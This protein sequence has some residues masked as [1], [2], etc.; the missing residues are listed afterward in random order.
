M[1]FE[2]P[3]L[4]LS[5]LRMNP[6]SLKYSL[7][8]LDHLSLRIHFPKILYFSTPKDDPDETIRVF[9]DGLAKTLE[10]L[11]IYAGSLSLDEN[12]DKPGSLAVQ[13]PYLTA[14]QILRIA[15][16][17]EKYDFAALESKE[18][19]PDG[20]DLGLVW[21]QAPDSPMPVLMAQLSLIRGGVL[22]YLGIHHC[23][24]GMSWKEYLNL[25]KPHHVWLS[26]HQI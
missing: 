9:L 2:E 12:A 13:A 1:V 26:K 18:F 6:N 24:M 7:S 11:P 21:P 20:I 19:P 25:S 5:E 15:D 4:K 16:L 23:V 22:L 8:P 10:H 14:D 3:P 17:R